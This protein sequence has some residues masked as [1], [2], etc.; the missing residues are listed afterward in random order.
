MAAF[1]LERQP[2]VIDPEAMQDGRVEIV[3]V[4][5]VGGHVVAVIVRGAERDAGT[6]PPA[7]HP[8]SEAARMVVAAVVGGSQA[9]LAVDGA[10]KLPAPDD[11][12][13]VEHAS[14]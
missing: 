6:D 11:E 2:G 8:D 9:T 10:P 14:L 7:R 3:P 13:V 1:E 5:R 12:R 4:Y